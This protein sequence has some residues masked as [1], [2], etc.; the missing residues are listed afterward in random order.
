MPNQNDGSRGRLLAAAERLFAERGIDA[1]SLREIL[2]ESG[3][4]HATAIQ[5]HFGGKDG[6][7]SAVLEERYARVDTRRDAML[8]QLEAETGDDPRA[9]AATLVRPLATELGDDRGRFFL[10]IYSQMVLRTNAPT[11]DDGSSIWRLR[12]L[13]QRTMPPDSPRLHPTFTALSFAMVEL[14]RRASGPPHADDRLFVSRLIDVVA[15]ILQTPVS[16]ETERLLR[17]RDTAG[18]AP[19]TEADHAR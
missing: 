14:A 10:Q 18:P 2:R 4:K 17:E 13:I 16:G 5:Y 8:D 19:G 6:L 12:S 1:V 9:L 11:S 15:A 3:V 7:L